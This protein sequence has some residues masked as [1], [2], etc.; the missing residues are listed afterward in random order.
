M[1][2]TISQSGI[3]LTGITAILI[4]QIGQPHWQ[5]YACLFGLAGQPFW[6]ASATQHQQWGVLILTLAY[7]AVWCL[8]LHKHWLKRGAK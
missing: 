3:A 6:I 5:K 7:T 8:G 1:I 4:T 2:D